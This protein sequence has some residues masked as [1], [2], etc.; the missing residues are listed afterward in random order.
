MGLKRD[1]CLM[2]EWLLNAHI[3]NN[4]AIRGVWVISGTSIYSPQL[5]C[6]KYQ[7]LSSDIAITTLV[8][9]TKSSRQF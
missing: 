4:N 5:V 3:N 7:Q 2:S 8:S 6:R 1:F 9:T